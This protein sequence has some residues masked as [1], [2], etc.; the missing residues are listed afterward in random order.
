ML[1]ISKIPEGEAVSRLFTASIDGENAPVWAI[2]VSAY[3]YNYGWPGHQRPEN[4]SEDS[5]YI[6][7]ES[8]KPVT[9]RVKPDR[10]FREAVIRPLSRGIK[11]VFDGDE[12]VFTLNC[13]G[14]YSLELDGHHN[15]LHIFFDEPKDYLADGA[16]YYGPGV[17]NVGVV[18]LYSGDTVVVDRGAVVIGG[19]F[20]VDADNIRIMGKGVIDGRYETRTNDTLLLAVDVQTWGHIDHDAEGFMRFMKRTDL[21]TG[22]IKL[23]NCRNCVIEGVIC[24]D[25]AAWAV[26]CYACSDL[27][28]DGI[29]EVGQWKYNTDGIDLMNCHDVLVERCFLRNY[30]DCMVLKGIKGWDGDNVYNITMR[31]LVVWCDW[32]RALEIGAET[33]ADEYYNI[34]FEDCDVIHAV[35]SMLDIQNGDRAYVHDV[36]FEDI[37]CEFTRYQQQD[38]LQTDMTVPYSD[39]QP[40]YQPRLIFVH[41]YTGQW[42][43][44][45]IPGRTSDVL[46]RNITVYPDVDTAKPEIDIC[47]YSEGH[48]VENVTVD[49]IFMNGRRLTHDDIRWTIGHHVGEI[50][51]N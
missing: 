29:K 24:V 25:S 39:P 4:Q 42:S 31:G 1:K 20:A 45:G 30:D 38:V 15:N 33:C 51:F 32:G 36:R 18:R 44:D 11:A 26:S 34:V 43:K 9:V 8:D 22:N 41:G 2:K 40:A 16:I 5:A 12:L 48:G 47:G 13:P 27:H 46:L 50:G 3:P 17:H 35:F 37:R 6:A 21:M 7:F 14:Q 10:K 19:F 28:I 23:Y 49:G